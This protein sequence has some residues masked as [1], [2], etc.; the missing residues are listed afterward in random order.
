MPAESTRTHGFKARKWGASVCIELATMP[1]EDVRTVGA[2]ISK[3]TLKHATRIG[4][5][6][7]RSSPQ[8]L[9]PLREIIKTLLRHPHAAQGLADAAKRY[10]GV[11]PHPQPR[12]GDDWKLRAE[13]GANSEI[14]SRDLGVE[15]S[16]RHASGG[17]GGEKGFGVGKLAL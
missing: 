11:P 1:N 17:I 4:P 8:A 3:R 5:S 15:R 13:L 12:R 9:K 6:T 10:F 16:E 2:F 14:L 7:L